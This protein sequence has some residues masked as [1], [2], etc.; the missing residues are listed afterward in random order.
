MV[1]IA[2]VMRKEGENCI[3]FL[4]PIPLKLYIL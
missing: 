4:H 1:L 3:V 2:I